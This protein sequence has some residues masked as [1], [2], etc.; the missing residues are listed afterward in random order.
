MATNNNRANSAIT[1]RSLSRVSISRIKKEMSDVHYLSD[2]LVITFLT[3][4]NNTTFDNPTTINGFAAMILMSGEV[5]IS[6]NMKEYDVKPNSLVFFNPN[7]IIRTLKSTANATA[8]L[9]VFSE[10]FVNEAQIEL[11][12]SIP[13]YM[14]FG[15]APVLGVTEED[16]AEIRQLFQ[17]I[18]TIIKSDKEMYRDE[19]IRT[20]FSVAFYLITEINQRDTKNVIKKGRSEVLFDEF[21][22]LV[23][24]HSTQERNVSFYAH[25]L[26]ITAK[27]LSSV[28]KQVSG[29]SAACWIDESVIL[30][31]QSLLKYSEM[32]IFEISQHLNFSTQSF[33][34]KYFKQHT[35][36]SPSRYKRK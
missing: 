35:G 7:S 11:S 21:I 13:V 22:E 36:S 29:K 14:R 18:K 23:Q 12:T 5:R 4:Q 17:L 10:K 25:K 30:N 34:G 31:A 33:F 15:K 8:F 9:L 27:Y 26:G 1:K 2:D 24:K 19:I 20:L 3:A 16:V 6:I 32:S 28:V